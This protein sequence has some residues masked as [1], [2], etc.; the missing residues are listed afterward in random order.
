MVGFLAD[1]FGKNKIYRLKFKLQSYDVGY[2]EKV[3]VHLGTGAS[4]AEQTT[5][6]GDYE[7]ESNTFVEYKVILPE[8]LESG[9]YHI[10]F[11]CHSEPYMFILYVTD[12]LLEE[13]S[14]GVLSGVVTNGQTP[15]EGVEVTIKDSETK[16]TTDEKGFY[17]FKELEA[18]NYTL[19]F[20]KTGYRYIEQSDIIV[21]M[22]DTTKINTTWRNCLLIP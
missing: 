18:G 8:R 11:H 10:S 5:L 22:G 19:T 21:E 17:E 16:C 1:S 4:V 15:L 14:E 12:V 13:V 6:L 3:A 9:N 20:N 2:P 7:V